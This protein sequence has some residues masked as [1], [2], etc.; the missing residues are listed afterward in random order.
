MGGRFQ[1]PAWSPADGGGGGR[2][3][4]GRARVWDPALPSPPR[5]APPSLQPCRGA[6]VGAGR[7]GCLGVGDPQERLAGCD[8]R[9]GAGRL[10]RLQVHRRVDSRCRGG[11]GVRSAKRAPFLWVPGSVVRGCPGARAATQ[12]DKQRECAC[13]GP[14]GACVSPLCVRPLRGGAHSL[15]VE[16]L[17]PHPYFCPL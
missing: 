3:I 2:A 15:V 9:P 16:R 7:Q 6:W 8:C 5:C 1:L 14:W 4:L 10:A 12:R 13:A 11:G 17:T